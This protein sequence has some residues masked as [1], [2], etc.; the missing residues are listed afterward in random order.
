LQHVRFACGVE[1]ALRVAAFQRAN[2][3]G[4]FG[5]AVNRGHD[6]AIDAVQL[7]PK[8]G[9]RQV[10]GL[11]QFGILAFGHSRNVAKRAMGLRPC[12]IKCCTRQPASL[13]VFRA[14]FGVPKSEANVK[15][16]GFAV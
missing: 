10:L 2:L 9:N 15:M 1:D 5:T 12:Q 4:N 6:L 16:A 7:L 11:R 13:A 14:T 3:A 8:F